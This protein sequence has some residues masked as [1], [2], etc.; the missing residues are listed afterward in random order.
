MYREK[1]SVVSKEGLQEGEFLIGIKRVGN[2]FYISNKYFDIDSS[3]IK[4]LENVFF[5][6]KCMQNLVTELPGL[7]LIKPLD[8]L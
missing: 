4:H 5:P 3:T 8:T 2:K 6:I 7:Y 1:D